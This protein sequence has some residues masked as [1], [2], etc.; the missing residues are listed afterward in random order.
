MRRNKILR[1]A[2]S[3]DNPPFGAARPST[4]D[5][6]N[7]PKR[8][9]DDDVDEDGVAKTTDTQAIFSNHPGQG[10][11]MAKSTDTTFEFEVF[12]DMLS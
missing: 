7:C 10:M 1:S 11:Y 6:E 5:Q 8:D 4:H 3:R 9:D 2:V 12:N